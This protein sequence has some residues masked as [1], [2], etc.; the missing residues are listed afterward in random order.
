MKI[1]A[2]NINSILILFIVVS[3][4]VFATI[5]WFD[6]KAEEVDQRID[7]GSLKVSFE[8]SDKISGTYRD[9]SQESDPLFNITNAQPG[10]GPFT[11]YIKVANLGKTPMNYRINF[12]IKE[13]Q[14]SSALSFE[15]EKVYFNG[16]NNGYN[17]TTLTGSELEIHQLTG[18]NLGEN[19]YEIYRLTL[20]L[21]I[22]SELN[23][24]L[25]MDQPLAYMF[26]LALF[27]W[28]VGAPIPVS[29]IPYKRK[30]ANI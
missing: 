22:N 26:D 15:I 10:D 14:L 18:E 7:V 17:K 25:S 21:N 12:I 5:A 4:F 28:Q 20:A 11:T 13:K 6:Q 1:K 2:L 24:D 9:I 30:D 8:A 16:S 3:G 27:G 23:I 29:D 19:D